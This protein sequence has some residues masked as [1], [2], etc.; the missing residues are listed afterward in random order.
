MVGAS[1]DVRGRLSPIVF[2]GCLTVSNSV[3]PSKLLDYRKTKSQSQSPQIWT[4]SKKLN[5]TAIRSSG[6][7]LSD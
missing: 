5:P 7:F 3:D 2:E 4:W 6:F 1:V